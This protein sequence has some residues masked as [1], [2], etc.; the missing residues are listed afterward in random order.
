MSPLHNQYHNIQY[1]P[2][3]LYSVQQSFVSKIHFFA[4]GRPVRVRLVRLPN[5]RNGS[6]RAEF[7]LDARDVARWVR[8]LLARRRSAR[9]CTATRS[10]C[11]LPRRPMARDCLTGRK[12]ELILP[13]HIFVFPVFL[14]F[15]SRCQKSI[16]LR[17]KVIWCGGLPKDLFPFWESEDCSSIL[18]CSKALL[19]NASL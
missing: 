13:R 17:R 8:E 11:G 10:P 12:C 15:M 7:P 6:L 14:A 16:W 1:H 5:P 18:V 19:V 4:H 2:I 9:R 3:R